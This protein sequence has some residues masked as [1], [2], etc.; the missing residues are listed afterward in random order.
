MLSEGFAKV[1]LPPAALVIAALVPVRRSPRTMLTVK[2]SVTFRL[3]PVVPLTAPNCVSG[4]ATL[5]PPMVSAWAL[6]AFWN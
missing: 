1:A 3:A 6:S 4:I 2:L 5:L